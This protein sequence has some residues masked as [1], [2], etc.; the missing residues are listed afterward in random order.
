VKRIQLID[1]N[2]REEANLRELNHDNVIELKC[3][4]ENE[5]FR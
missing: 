3:L 2:P 1:V 4:E 5:N